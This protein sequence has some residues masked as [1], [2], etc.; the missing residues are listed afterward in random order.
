[1]L[2]HPQLRNTSQNDIIRIVEVCS[3]KRFHLEKIKNEQDGSE[4]LCVRANQGHSIQDVEVST[5]EISIN[6]KVDEII[7]GTF[8]KAWDSIKTQVYTWLRLRSI[9]YIIRYK[10]K[11][12]IIQIEFK[13]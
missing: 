9:Y 11:K 3:K 4:E 6:D 10:S 2:K 7:H 13:I 12:I 8:Y 5:T 1:M